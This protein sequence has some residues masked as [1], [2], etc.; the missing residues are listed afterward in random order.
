MICDSSGTIVLQLSRRS[1]THATLTVLQASQKP[2][3]TL[4]LHIAG[5][6]QPV[7][8]E[9]IEQLIH[10]SV[11][12]M[13]FSFISCFVNTSAPKISVNTTSMNQ[14]TAARNPSICIL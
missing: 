10:G 11:Y 2:R 4:L 5:S 8:A 14:E 6:S 1:I 12:I 9:N 13:V 3:Q 7:P